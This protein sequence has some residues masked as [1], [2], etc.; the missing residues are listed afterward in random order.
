MNNLFEQFL[1]KLANSQFND[2][3]NDVKKL[4]LTKIEDLQEY[5]DACEAMRGYDL[6]RELFELG[7]DDDY[8]KFIDTL[9]NFGYKTY[10]EAR[11]KENKKSTPNP[12]CECTKNE[13]PVEQKKDLED[14]GEWG[15]NNNVTIGNIG[16]ALDKE[17][18]AIF[19]GV[20]SDNNSE[21]FVLKNPKR[22]VDEDGLDQAD[23]LFDEITL[24]KNTW[25]LDEA[26]GD[27]AAIYEGRDPFEYNE[28]KIYNE[29]INS[30]VENF[31]NTEDYTNNKNNSK[32]LLKK[33]TEFLDNKENDCT[34]EH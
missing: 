27:E 26:M 23:T 10:N 33:Y 21:K 8:D 6:L 1:A 15:Y 13:K 25:I 12:N 31:M 3:E 20:V 19:I 17:H 30:L 28:E 29:E 24:S 14:E 2:V 18:N 34:C 22:I 11:D 9:K 16:V 4:D 7:G 5:I 32:A